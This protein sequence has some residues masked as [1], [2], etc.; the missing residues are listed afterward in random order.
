MQSV[1]TQA[2]R[3]L[4]AARA[5][6]DIAE[7]K[8]VSQRKYARA[9]LEQARSDYD[10]NLDAERE[11]HA[12]EVRGLRARVATLSVE[13]RNAL[14]ERDAARAELEAERAGPV[15]ALTKLEDERERHAAENAAAMSTAIGLREER[16]TARAELDAERERVR[17]LCAAVD[18]ADVDSKRY[19]DHLP[20]GIMWN[21][22]LAARAALAKGG[23]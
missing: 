5:R 12:E 19:V 13:L 4:A 10:K 16:D 11:R 17:E 18:S 21:R 9:R 3:V 7:S 1:A 8:L 2:G 22:V 15:S 6:V 20:G 14:D 23:G